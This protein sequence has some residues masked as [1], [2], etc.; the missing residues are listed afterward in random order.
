MIK[1]HGIQIY[2]D[3][4]YQLSDLHTLKLD[5]GNYLFILGVYHNLHCLVRRP[6]FFSIALTSGPYTSD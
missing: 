3:E 1:A 2:P 4:A 5:N 6:R